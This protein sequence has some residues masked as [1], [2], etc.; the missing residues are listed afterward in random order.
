MR[1]LFYLF[2]FFIFQTEVSAQ[3]RCD[4]YNMNEKAIQRDSSI[5]KT[6]K[7]LEEFTKEYIKNKNKSESKIIIPIVFH[8]VHNYGAEN[9]SKEQV[10]DAVR[11]LNEDFQKLN[12]DTA[13]VVSDFKS[14]IADCNIEFRLARID[15]YG[16]CTDGI[17]RTASLST[18]NGNEETKLIAPSWDRSKYLNIW[19]VKT[20]E[21]G[22]AGYS[23]YPSS[24]DN[25]W[26]ENADGV[27]LVSS[28]VGSIGTSNN[29]Q[30]RT[31]TH[32][33]GHYLNLMHTWGSSNQPGLASNCDIDDEVDDTPNT[34]GHT[35]CDLSASTCGYHDNV[36][37]YME[38]SYCTNMFTNGQKDRMRACLA[39]NISH[40]IN[41]WSQNNLIATGTKDGYIA[42]QCVPIPDFSLDPSNGC[43][44]VSVQF[45]DFSYNYDSINTWKWVF[46]GGIPDTS[47][48]ANPIVIYNNPGGYDVSLTVSNSTGSNQITKNGTVKIY[49]PEIG[50]IF[51]FVEDFEQSVFPAY[52]ND[53]SDNWT[54]KQSGNQ[55]WKW[56]SN[57]SASGTGSI[58]IDNSINNNNSIN[59]I[60]SPNI[61]LSRDPSTRLT[62]KYAYAKNSTNSKSKF[63]VYVS[64]DCMST[65]YQRF[66][67]TDN[68][69]V[70]NG[71][72][73]V[74]NFIPD[75][76]EWASASLTLG[77]FYDDQSIRIKFEST[78]GIDDG[79]LYIDN[80]TLS[81]NTGI[82][83]LSDTILYNISISPNPFDF[84]T[85]INLEINNENKI[86]FSVFDILGNKIGEFSKIFKSGISSVLFSDIV[87]KIDAGIYF[88]KININNQI[89]TFKVICIK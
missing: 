42:Q 67:K 46:T 27:I 33:I 55:T 83:D 24:V 47:N 37:N 48:I 61:I 88:V 1:I 84:D 72:T 65:W 5:L 69:L 23:Y 4:T 9:I 66:S 36:Q 58:Y 74:N 12:P 19:V 52:S 32:E 6:K 75:N 64:T 77:P 21:L 53:T 59:S 60:I 35:D 30:S 81:S 34:I 22:A 54:I 57:A 8:I 2:L 39:S 85:K 16:H 15:P 79:N 78:A 82:N 28:Y 86:I 44:G 45:T 63:K 20:I 41:L 71:G 76:D 68:F 25:S 56:T 40:R 51:P 13:N 18:Y 11:V 87:T 26:G 3:F 29:Y 14:I 49:D 62:F 31:L 50:K 17:T 38:Y 70:T 89:K 73:F 43:E 80:I 10:L 7:Q